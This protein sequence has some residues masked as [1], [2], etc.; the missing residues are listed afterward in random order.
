MMNGN[1]FLDDAAERDVRAWELIP[2]TEGGTIFPGYQ[3]GAGTTA[4]L[5]LGFDANGVN[6]RLVK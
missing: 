6:D 3:L 5:A 1:D 2:A 4:R